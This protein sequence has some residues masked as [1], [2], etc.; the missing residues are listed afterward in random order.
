MYLEHN[1]LHAIVN[2]VHAI[3]AG[4]EPTMGLKSNADRGSKLK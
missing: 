2:E 1:M 3:A 4:M